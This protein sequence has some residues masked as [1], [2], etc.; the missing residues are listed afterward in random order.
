MQDGEEL[1]V[2]MRPSVSDLFARLIADAQTWVKAELALL[3]CRGTTLVGALRSA[4]ILILVAALLATV[5]LFALAI[6]LILTLATIVGPGWATA[7]VVVTL[8]AI[9]GLCG[10]LG[11]GRIKGAI[12]DQS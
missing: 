1:G 10:W 3:K 2:P 11:V 9:A 12:E 7:I 8:L 4:V 5:A 6:G